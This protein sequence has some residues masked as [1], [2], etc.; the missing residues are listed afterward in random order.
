MSYLVIYKIMKQV[1][2]EHTVIQTQAAIIQNSL[3][4]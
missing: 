2:P 4:R 3:Y 1:D